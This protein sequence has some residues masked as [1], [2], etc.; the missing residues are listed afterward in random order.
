[1]TTIPE[2]ILA[3]AAVRP[4]APAVTCGDESLTWSELAEG[5]AR[6]GAQLAAAG[7][8]PGK[9]VTIALPNS[10]AFVK[11]MFG[12]WWIGATPAPISHRLPAAERQAIIDVSEPAV[13]IDAPED[14]DGAAEP[15]A[16]AAT[17]SLPWKA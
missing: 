9:L 15:I 5:A 11:A 2:Q 13:V 6:A 12:A 1:M 7:A 17:P 3:H 14:L 16:P 10:V 4:D 8:R